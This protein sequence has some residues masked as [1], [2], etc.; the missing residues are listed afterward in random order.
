LTQNI[1]SEKKDPFDVISGVTTKG[2]AYELTT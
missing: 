1:W 2:S